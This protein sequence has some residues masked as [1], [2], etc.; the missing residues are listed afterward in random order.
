MLRMAR[1]MVQHDD[2]AEPFSAKEAIRRSVKMYRERWF[3][4]L[5]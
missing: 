3:T 4:L 1:K 5:I 2:T